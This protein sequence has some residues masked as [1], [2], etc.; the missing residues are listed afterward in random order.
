MN[1]IPVNP[2]LLPLTRERAVLD[3]L[4]LTWWSP[5]SSEW[6]AREVQPTPKIELDTAQYAYLVKA[7]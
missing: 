5:E 6:G 1:R 4:A 3:T 2:E 7:N